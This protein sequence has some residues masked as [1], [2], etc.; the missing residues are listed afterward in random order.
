[1]TL[2]RLGRAAQL[3][4]VSVDTVRRHA[5]AGRVKTTRTDGQQRLIDGAD[6]ARLAEEL[7]PDGATDGES[8]ARNHLL[9]I[10][11]RVVS[12][13]VA[14]Q[15]EMRCGPF[16]VVSLLTRESVDDLGLEPGVMVHAVIKATNVIVERAGGER[17]GGERAGGEREP[18]PR[19]GGRKTTSPGR[20]RRKDEANPGT[21]GP[22]GAARAKAGPSERARGKPS[23]GPGERG[24]AHR[25]TESDGSDGS[26]GAGRDAA[27]GGLRRSAATR[28]LALLSMSLFATLAACGSRTADRS[29]MVFAAASLT[30]AFQDLAV[31]Y[32][33]AHPG[34][35]V[36]LHFAGTPQL[37][38]Q[39]REGAPVDVF[40]SA[41]EANMQR[42]VAMGGT[43]GPPVVFARNRLTIVTAE[44]NPQGIRG[45]AD[46]ARD[47]LRVVLCGPQV[48][49]GRYAREALA[50]AG[51]TVRSRS[52][53]PSVK[54]VVSKVQLGEVDAG[55]VYVTDATSAAQQVDAVPIPA[56]HDVVATYPIVALGAG[57][58]PAGAAA[59][60]AF[61]RSDAG[62]AI[63]QRHGFARP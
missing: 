14:A 44:G 29:T 53:E 41:D 16:R 36:E 46:L 10:V 52:D 23:G 5:D 35:G 47:D 49:A 22:R 12:D 28:L 56:E 42:I 38:V 1:M 57:A 34:E 18:G 25:G 63:L 43:L 51:V 11:T 54:A 60:L 6:L 17:A 27:D 19:A 48:P 9:G 40:A 21:P 33:A 58:N 20:D 4:G 61:V 31:A 26:D 55:I 13:K 8:S 24:R 50:K 62:L 3:L 59:F 37:V 30:A 45:L 15:V 39:I 7:E 2:Y 32:E